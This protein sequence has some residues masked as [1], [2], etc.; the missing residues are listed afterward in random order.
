MRDI[1]Q[2]NWTLQKVSN[3]VQKCQGR[4]E[5]KRL[6]NYFRLKETREILDLDPRPV[7]GI[8]EIIDEM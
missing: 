1:L 3:A 8:M 7:K 4:K 2:N 5:K 6:R